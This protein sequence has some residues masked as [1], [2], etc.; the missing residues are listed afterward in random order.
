MGGGEAHGALCVDGG[1]VVFLLTSAWLWVGLV[2][3]ALPHAFALGVSSSEADPQAE[4][5]P[6]CG[7]LG[8]VDGHGSVG[9]VLGFVDA[10]CELAFESGPGFAVWAF[11]VA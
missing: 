5:F 10:L 7:V 9:V 6:A 8:D 3:A 4:V 2:K 11:V 1:M